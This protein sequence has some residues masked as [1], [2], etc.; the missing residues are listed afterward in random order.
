MTIL[1]YEKIMPLAELPLDL[2]V[3]QE[4]VHLWQ[5][6]LDLPEDCVEQLIPL[7]SAD[8]QLRAGR[9]AQVRL[10]HRFI[11]GRGILRLLLASYLKMAA[12]EVA[13]VYGKHGKPDLAPSAPLPIGFNVS[14]SHQ[15][16][17]YAM[18]FD[19]TIGVDLE[20][21]RPM[22][23]VE[24]L[25]QRFFSAQ[26]YEFLKT[27]PSH[28][29]SEV[30]FRLWT[31]KEA[32][33]KATGEGLAGLQQVEVTLALD[34]PQAALQIQGQ[35]NFDWTLMEFQSDP[36]YRAALAVAGRVEELGYYR[37]TV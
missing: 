29:R 3:H 6:N 16:A 28:L 35:P 36:E 30:F 24:Q 4:A 26:E 23:N 13:F 15:L 1:S 21:M 11:V 34:S 31:C 22:S 37:I 25:A 5:V 20:Q 18:T 8:E 17:L 7:L 9:F 12:S 33:L 19:R 27:V 2:Q 10:Q 32:Y 14:H